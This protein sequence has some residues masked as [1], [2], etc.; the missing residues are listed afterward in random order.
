MHNT[1]IN[2]TSTH[3]VI[4]LLMRDAE[5]LLT[6]GCAPNPNERLRTIEAFFAYRLLLG[7]TPDLATE[8]RPIGGSR[9]T[10]R[11]FLSSL[12]AS[13]EFGYSSGIF[14]SNRMLMSEVEGF[15]FWFNSSDREMGV[16]MALGMYEPHV[17]AALKKMLRP[18]MRCLDIGAQPGFFT[19]LMA[20]RVGESGSVTAFEPM[21]KSFRILERNVLE[22]KF[23][24]RVIRHNVAASAKT[25]EVDGVAVSNMY[26]VGNVDGGEPVR[27][28]TIPIDEVV[29]EP[30]DLV[31]IDIEGHEPSALAGMCKIIGRF[32]PVI[33][34]EANEYWLRKCS[35]TNSN[36]YVQ[37]L[38]DYGYDVH[39]LNKYPSIIVPGQ[40]QLGELGCI[41]LIAVPKSK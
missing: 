5:E 39:D 21:P 17:V 41:D 31:K 37:K 23:F 40:L 27:F 36:E 35:S 19:C 26:V 14:P 24:G 22:N 6:S 10:F 12:L 15:R 38:V 2:D 20:S 13:P 34:T 11:E 9:Q 1:V 32:R 3:D 8:I 30:I 7:R 25:S 33:I 16:P 28:K 29:I 4:K 18:G